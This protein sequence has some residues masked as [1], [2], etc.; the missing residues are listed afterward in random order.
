MQ[1]VNVSEGDT[2]K[3]GDEMQSPNTGEWSAVPSQW[4]GMKVSYSD[5]NTFSRFKI[6]VRR[7]LVIKESLPTVKQHGQPKICPRCQGAGHHKWGRDGFR[8]CLDCG[9]TGKLQA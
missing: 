7:A 2:F 8:S 5:N 6:R 9:G 3:S 4:Y 1:Y